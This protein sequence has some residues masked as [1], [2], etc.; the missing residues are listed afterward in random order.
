MEDDLVQQEYL[1]S[2]D[3]QQIHDNPGGKHYCWLNS[4][5]D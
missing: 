2:V 5:E 1:L 3:Y 4:A